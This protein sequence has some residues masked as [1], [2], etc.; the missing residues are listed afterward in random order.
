MKAKISVVIPFYCTPQS[1]FER[2]MNSLLVEATKGLEIIVIDDGSPAEYI[3]CLKKY[4]QNENLRVIYSAHGGVSVARNRGIREST[5]EWVMFVDSDDYVDSSSLSSILN[6]VSQYDGDVHLF[7]GGSDSNGVIVNNTS[8][9]KEDHDYGNDAGDK[10]AIMESALTAGVLPAGYIQKFS[11]GSPYCKLFRRDFLVGNKLNFDEN[12]K[13][14]EDTLFALNIYYA[15]RSIYYHDLNLY[16][17]V[18]NSQSATRK[19][20]PGL[21]KDMDVFF[22][23]IKNFISVN[24][25]NTELDK[26]YYLRSQI[27]VGRVF[28]LEFF[29]TENK[30]T[31]RR[32]TYLAFIARD[33]YRTALNKNYMPGG[34]IKRRLF[35][36]M[37]KRGYGE[38][39]QALKKLS[40]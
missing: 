13:F 23:K 25:L 12:V 18:D 21:S 15:A 31:N 11:Y 16:Y 40:K 14:A 1:L 27:E 20:R 9:L 8:F 22:E 17:Y 7:G 3:E 34:G 36:Y 19:F 4:E 38:I 26:A 24:H 28:S 33:P 5:A 39:Y 10:I 32:K 30:N 37:I 2:C 35:Q 29:N 6:E